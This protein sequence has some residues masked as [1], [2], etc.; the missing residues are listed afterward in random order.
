MALQNYVDQV[1]PVV[2]AEVLNELDQIRNVVTVPVALN[3]LTISTDSTI[4]GTLTVSSTTNLVTLNGT[5]VATFSSAGNGG[6]T[7]SVVLSSARPQLNLVETD[8]GANLGR[9]KIDAQSGVLSMSCITDAGVAT[10]FLTVQRALGVPTG[11]TIPITSAPPIYPILFSSATP[12]FGINETDAAANNRLYDFIAASEQLLFRLVNDAGNSAASWMILDRTANTVDTIGF[13]T[14]RVYIGTDDASYAKLAVRQSAATDSIGF[15][16]TSAGSGSTTILNMSNALDSDCQFE[17]SQ[18]GAATKFFSIGPST[19]TALNLVTN[20]SNRI[21]ISSGGAVAFPGIG[22]TASAAN[23][24]LDSGASNN[25]L[26]STSSIRY[27]TDVQDLSSSDL[28]KLFDLRPITYRSKCEGDNPDTRHYGLI[29]EEVADILP[30]LVHYTMLRE[31]EE[32]EVEDE[33]GEKRKEKKLKS[34]RVAPEAV[35]YERLV[36]LL[37]AKMKEQQEEIEDLKAQFAQLKVK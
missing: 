29:A 21:T 23:A 24:F 27:K 18:Q 14:G 36:V 16:N 3:S 8:A 35:Q 6:N 25:L 22:T 34:E 9:W 2:S 5:G 19:A 7:A 1:G 10:D 4:N 32:V 15:I 30:S 11:I 13:P 26:R 28:A 31:F 37:L 12:G 17:L 33:S 20:T